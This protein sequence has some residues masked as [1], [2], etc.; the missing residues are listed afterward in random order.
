MTTATKRILFVDDEEHVLEGLRNL[1]RRQRHVWDMVFVTSGDAALVELEKAPFDVIV[2]DMRMPGMDG[3]TL[4]LHV[5]SRYPSVVRIVLSGH[6]E[7]AAMVRA[8]S[9]AHQFLSKP[10]EADTLRAAL[11]RTCALRD[12]LSH[13][14]IRRA[15]G[16]LDRLPSAPGAYWELARAL[17]QSDV[18]WQDVAAIIERD[19]AMAVKVLQL[20]NSPFFGLS[21]QVVSVQQAVMYLGVDLLKGLTLGAHVFAALP[22]VQMPGFSLDEFQRHAQL[23]A[24]LARHF[25]ADPVRI[26]ESFTAAMIHDIGQVVLALGMPVEFAEVRREVRQ[27]GRPID[28][29][30]TERLG[31]THAAVGAYLLGLWGLPFPIVEAVAYH[32][33]PSLVTS[34]PREVLAAVHVSEAF[35]EAADESRADARIDLAFLEQAGLSAKLPQWRTIAARHTSRDARVTT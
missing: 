19:T 20:V 9:V 31:V 16:Q 29:I 13:E 4:L 18:A 12:L 28:Q 22:S 25:V 15:A 1:F 32:H 21:R 5:K 34:G 3:A 6:A 27:T 11:E 24:E 17:A 10:C 33:E 26:D 8:L 23:T 30:E 7:R 2:S 14:P 35:A